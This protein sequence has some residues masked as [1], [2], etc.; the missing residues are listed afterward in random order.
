[1]KVVSIGDIHG[2]TGWKKIIKEDFD[3]SEFIFLGD[4]TDPYRVERISESDSIENLIEILELKKKN[5]EKISLLL[6]N[7]DAQYLYYPNFTKTGN[8]SR[9]YLQELLDIYQLNQNLFQIAVQKNNYLFTHAGI[10]AGWFQEHVQLF[11]Q[12]GL[13]EDNSNL[14]VILNKIGKEPIWRKILGD[15]SFYRNGRDR[16]AGPLWADK[17]ELEKDL[18]LPGFHQ[19][20]GHNKFSSIITTGDS[21]TSITF[22]DCLFNENV[23]Y[24]LDI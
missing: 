13:K 3:D 23:P 8:L 1:M 20:V 15:I 5:P 2:R 4:Y 12:F 21:E 17:L 19:I 9:L 7:H 10:N 6:G 16:Y 18:L 14:A 24:I 22:C 11:I